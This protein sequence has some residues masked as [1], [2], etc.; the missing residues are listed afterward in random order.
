MGGWGV[1][2]WQ[3]R[4][5][6]NKR[7]KVNQSLNQFKARNKRLRKH[8][9][10]Y[11]EF[12]KSDNWKETRKYFLSFEKNKKCYICK[13]DKNIN[14]HHVSYVNIFVPSLRKRALHLV[15][16]C[17]DCHHFV[18]KLARAKNYGLRQVIKIYKKMRLST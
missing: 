15:T 7:M 14:V 17:Q 9:I 16:L 2:T 13:S 11:L 5:K 4:V 8:Q 3:F 18:H 12:L 6:L 10:I 1:V